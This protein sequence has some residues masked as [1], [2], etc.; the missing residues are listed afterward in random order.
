MVVIRFTW[1]MS[2]PS[3]RAYRIEMAPTMLPVI[4][5]ASGMMYIL[6]KRGFLIKSDMVNLPHD[7]DF[8]WICRSIDEVK[9][10]SP[11]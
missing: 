6:S 4:I 11:F 2:A 1:K 3:S 10:L 8:A 9:V 7:I 5:A